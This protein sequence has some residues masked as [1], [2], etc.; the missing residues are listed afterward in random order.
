[1][2]FAWFWSCVQ[3]YIATALERIFAY[4]PNRASVTLKLLG[5]SPNVPR[6]YCTWVDHCLRVRRT[7]YVMYAR[8]LTP[9][10]LCMW[11]CNNDQPSNRVHVFKRVSVH[12]QMIQ[13]WG[14][15]YG[16]HKYRYF[17]TWPSWKMASANYAT[18]KFDSHGQ[19]CYPNS[20]PSPTF[21]VDLWH[22]SSSHLQYPYLY[23]ISSCSHRPPH[24]SWS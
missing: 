5:R 1:M 19:T 16:I 21:P 9:W 7:G 15:F 8:Q 2:S 20:S 10:N 23:Q 11:T 17:Y 12:L 22:Q 3:C 24:I 4:F 18:E 13:R 6:S 14:Q